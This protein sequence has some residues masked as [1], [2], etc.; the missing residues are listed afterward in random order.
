M[1][2]QY[3]LAFKSNDHTPVKAYV[4]N[5]RDPYYRWLYGDN[6]NLG[7]VGSASLKEV[8]VCRF[9]G[10]KKAEEAAMLSNMP[11]YE[12]KFTPEAIQF[13]RVKPVAFDSAAG[14]ELNRELRKVGAGHQTDR[15]KLLLSPK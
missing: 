7:E 11:L 8:P 1:G 6:I 10:E 13:Y 5:R 15:K 2:V 14:F 3:H 12:P 9:I 4:T